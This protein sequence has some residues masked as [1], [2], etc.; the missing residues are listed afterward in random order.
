MRVVTHHWLRELSPPYI[1]TRPYGRPIEAFIAQRLQK[2]RLE[3]PKGLAPRIH[4]CS[5]ARQIR[6]ASRIEV[7]VTAAHLGGGEERCRLLTIYDARWE[8][9]FKELQ[10]FKDTFGHCNVPARYTAN[11]RLGQWVRYQRREKAQVACEPPP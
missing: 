10:E 9:R 11:E 3:C 2:K 6:A 7:A 8:Q 5:S 4:R 1:P